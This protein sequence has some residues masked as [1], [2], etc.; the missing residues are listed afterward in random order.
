MMI[1][2]KEKRGNMKKILS[3]LVLA[4]A[5]PVLFA[6]GGDGGSQSGEGEESP[7]T[8]T[9]KAEILALG[10]LIEVNVTEAE[11]ASGLYWIIT[12]DKTEFLDKD[13]MKTEKTALAV[14]DTVYIT[15]NGQVMMSYPP[16]VAALSV[17]KV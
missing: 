1:I 10:E 9:M 12:S 11:Y 7:D 8:F 14:G 4:L 13:G 3:I 5:L 15:Y 16:K 17:K 6:C 2:I